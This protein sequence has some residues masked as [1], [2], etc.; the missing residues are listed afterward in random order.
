M[1]DFK[2]VAGRLF[3]QMQMYTGRAAGIWDSPAGHSRV[4]IYIPRLQG[5]GAGRVRIYSM[6]GALGTTKKTVWVDLGQPVHHVPKTF[7]VPAKI[8]HMTC[9]SY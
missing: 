9:N 3:V 5:I 1:R 4:S 6:L 8:R 7:G 2:A